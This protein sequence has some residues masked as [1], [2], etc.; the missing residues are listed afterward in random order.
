MSL[1]HEEIAQLIGTSSETVTR[2]LSEF[3]QKKLAQLRGSTLLILN[4]A[5]MEKLIETEAR[6]SPGTNP[7]FS[8]NS[9]ITGVTLPILGR[10]I[11]CGL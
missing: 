9:R 8:K 7:T 4:K 11:S 2:M 10:S 1:T 3:R 5:G 6:I